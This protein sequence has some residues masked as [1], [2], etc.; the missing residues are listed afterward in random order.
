MPELPRQVPHPA[1]RIRLNRPK[2]A[3]GRL[4]CNAGDGTGALSLWDSRSHWPTAQ[5]S[6]I[7]QEVA[8]PQ[9]LQNEQEFQTSLTT[10]PE[11][12][13]QLFAATWTIQEG[14]GWPLAKGVRTPTL[15]SDL[16]SP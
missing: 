14:Q 9:H 13:R 10:L 6:Q 1:R 2:R 12:G 5:N 3:D 16:S 11:F 8:I 15:L 7:G 4:L